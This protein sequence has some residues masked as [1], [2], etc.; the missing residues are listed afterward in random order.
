MGKGIAAGVACARGG[1]LCILP[2]LALTL[3]IVWV[4]ACENPQPPVPCGAI[5]QQAVFTGEATTVQACFDDPNGDALSYSVAT[6]DPGVATA[7]VAGRTVTIAGVA[8]GTAFLT[9][10]AADGGGLTAEERVRV[11][12]PNRPPAA[13]GVIPPLEMAVGDSAAMDVSGYFDDPDGEGLSYAAAVSDADVA[14]VSAAGSVVTASG[15][16]KGTATVTVTATDPGDW[17][18]RRTLW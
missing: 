10:T 8:P 18:R 2:V 16:R 13:V 9:V 11:L 12:V 6:S 4:A 5:P 1:P 17:R 7:T 15:H 3:A 14:T